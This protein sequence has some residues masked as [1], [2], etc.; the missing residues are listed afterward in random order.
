MIIGIIISCI[1]LLAL[2]GYAWYYRYR[3]NKRKALIVP[4][5]VVLMRPKPPAL[6]ERVVK[7]CS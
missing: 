5:G 2:I 7:H 3:Q 6:Y 4:K 1:I